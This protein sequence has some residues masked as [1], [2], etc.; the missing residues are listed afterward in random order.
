MQALRQLGG[1]ISLALAEGY[2]PQPPPTPTETQTVALSVPPTALMPTSFDF[3][4][5]PFLSDTPTATPVPPTNCPPP[6]GWMLVAVGPGETLEILAARYKT[7]PEAL[8]ATNCLVSPSIPP[9]YSLY[10]PRLP[11]STPIPCGAPGG[12]VQYTVQPSDNLYRISQLYRVTVL[13]LQQA[14]CLGYS[15]TIFTGQRL[16]VPNVATSTPPLPLVTIEFA[17]VTP[18]PTDTPSPT[19]TNTSTSTVPPTAN[20]VPPS[21][22]PSPTPTPTGTNTLPPAALP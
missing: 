7:T 15:T 3:L 8:S 13:Q 4:L 10:V 16:W 19:A 2:V 18:V 20:T 11:T 21:E 12:W 14:N 17:T 5:S 1:G 6:S 22:T 9:G